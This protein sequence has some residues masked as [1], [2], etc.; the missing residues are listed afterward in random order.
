[1]KKKQT[2]YNMKNNQARKR[3]KEKHKKMHVDAETHIFV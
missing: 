1:M 2:N 3:A